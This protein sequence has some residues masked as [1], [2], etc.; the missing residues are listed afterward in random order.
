MLLAVDVQ[1]SDEGSTTAGVAF[2]G[3]KDHAPAETFLSEMST[4]AEYKPG[5]FYERELP[6]ILRLLEK[7]ALQPKLIVVDGYVFLDGKQRPGLGKYLFDVLGGTVPV[8][9]VAKTAFDGIGAEFQVLRGDSRKPLFVTCAGID[10]DEAK[11]NIHGM[12]GNYR[13]PTLL[14]TAD[15]LCRQ[16]PSS[17]QTSG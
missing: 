3:W 1:Y 4:A 8:I 5:Q 9:G 12:C 11:A 10:L 13:I 15:Q 16:R 2:D 14:K 6:C 7:F 17:H